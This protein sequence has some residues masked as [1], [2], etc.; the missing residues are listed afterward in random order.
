MLYKYLIKYI[1]P[2]LSKA[3]TATVFGINHWNLCCV[4]FDTYP[5]LLKKNNGHMNNYSAS[6]SCL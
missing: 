1:T 3:S 2:L 4:D 6:A 5:N